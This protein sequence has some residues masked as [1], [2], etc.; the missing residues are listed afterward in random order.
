M[1]FAFPHPSIPTGPGSGFCWLVFTF[2]VTQ[3]SNFDKVYF[4]QPHGLDSTS[5]EW[6]KPHRGVRQ[7]PPMTASGTAEFSSVCNP[8]C[9]DTILYIVVGLLTSIE[10]RRRSRAEGDRDRVQICAFYQR[11]PFETLCHKD[12]KPFQ[13]SC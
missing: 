9:M 7:L 1:P 10:E 2:P 12:G 8:I 11:R 3:S 6:F 13:L 4:F 5:V